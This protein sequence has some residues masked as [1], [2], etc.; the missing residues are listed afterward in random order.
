MPSLWVSETEPLIFPPLEQDAS[1]DLVAL[2]E[3]K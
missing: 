3:A 2:H 1:C